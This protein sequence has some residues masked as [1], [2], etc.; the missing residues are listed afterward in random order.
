MGG[1]TYSLFRKGDYYRIFPC[2]RQLK[3]E[4]ALKNA[5]VIGRVKEHTKKGF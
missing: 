2:G 3:L 5:E 4:E 1:K